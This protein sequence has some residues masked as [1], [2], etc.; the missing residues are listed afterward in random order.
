MA[1]GLLGV[2]GD[3]SSELSHPSGPW[4]PSLEPRGARDGGTKGLG[5]GGTSALAPPV[6]AGAR[7]GLGA[8]PGL[9]PLAAAAAA[10][11]GRAVPCSV[12]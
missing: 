6:G 2:W 7:G 1:R 4:V 9:E 5:R 11:P 12:E 3:R 10:L 8:V